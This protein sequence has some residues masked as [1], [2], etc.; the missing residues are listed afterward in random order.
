MCNEIIAATH[1]EAD[2]GSL[3]LRANHADDVDKATIAKVN[4]SYVHNTEDNHRVNIGFTVQCS[5]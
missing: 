4:C 3:E 2:D 1:H 5:A